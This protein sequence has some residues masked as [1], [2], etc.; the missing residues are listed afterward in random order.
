MK[1]ELLVVGKLNKKYIQE[2]CKDYLS[3]I[4][5]FAK[6]EVHELPE[7]KQSP[8]QNLESENRAI[9]EKLEKALAKGAYCIALHPAGFQL[10]STQLAERLAERQLNGCSHFCFVIG[11]SEGLNTQVLRLCDLQLSFSPMTFPHQLFRLMLLEQIYRAFKIN[12]GQVYH[13]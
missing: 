2:G 7:G 9:S 1:V 8:S 5:R 11:A 10:S 3:R 12:A 4:A 13:K 6:V